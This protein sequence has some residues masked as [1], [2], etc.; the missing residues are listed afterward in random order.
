MRVDNKT[1]GEILHAAFIASKCSI[2]IRAAVLHILEAVD[3][4]GDAEAGPQHGEAERARDRPGHDAWPT[5]CCS[6][7]TCLKVNAIRLR[8]NN[9]QEITVPGRRSK[10]PWQILDQSLEVEGRRL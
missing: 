5:V 9:Q 8:H 10:Q 2:T 4:E 3:T 1:F 7:H 6:C